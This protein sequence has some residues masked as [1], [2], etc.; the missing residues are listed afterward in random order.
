VT[1]VRQRSDY[2]G[3]TPARVLPGHLNYQF[4]DLVL[5]RR[6]TRIRALLA[7]RSCRRPGRAPCRWLRPT[8]NS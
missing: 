3:I 4:H 2:P 1:E 7:E 6:P 8:G 5:N